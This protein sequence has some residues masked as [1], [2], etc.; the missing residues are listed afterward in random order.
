L[1]DVFLSF[2]LA[3]V[4][5][6]FIFAIY[7]LLEMGLQVAPSILI[8]SIS[9]MPINSGD[10]YP[11]L[12]QGLIIAAS[13]L[14]G[15][16]TFLFFESV[17]YINKFLNK[18]LSR[19]RVDHYFKKMFKSSV[20]AIMIIPISFLFISIFFAFY[21]TIFYGQT[22]T[23]TTE[24]ISTNSIPANVLNIW[25][26]TYFG[27]IKNYSHAGTTAYNYYQT[28]N[29]STQGSIK[30]LYLAS[31]IIISILLFYVLLVFGL[32]EYFINKHQAVG[33]FIALGIGASFLYLLKLYLVSYVIVA[34]IMIA[35]ILLVYSYRKAQKGNKKTLQQ[36]KTQKTKTQ[37]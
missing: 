19:D 18:H 21:A 10:A 11:I 4:I 6:G 27:L 35:L 2:F 22:L 8:S 31:S 23:Y 9:N 20:I 15:F 12:L 34:V 26:S 32:V 3:I 13:M 17:K 5:V 30:M 1:E 28:L 29:T 25:N 33:S 14:F 16:Y 36:R 24:Q 37:S 7:V